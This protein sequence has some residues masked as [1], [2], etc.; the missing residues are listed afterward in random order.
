MASVLKVAF[1][2]SDFLGLCLERLLSRPDVAV[3]TVYAFDTDDHQRIKFVAGHAGVPLILEP[4][5]LER[6]AD[7]MRNVDVILTAGYGRKVPDFGVRFA[8]NLHPTLLP[9]GRGPWPIPW[10]LSDY[11][12]GGGVTL[13]AHTSRFDEGP[14]V[15]QRQIP[16][17]DRL[18]FEAYAMICNQLGV[19]IVSRFFDQPEAQ[20][21]A[22][23]PQEPDGI[24]S[25]RAFPDHRR[26][27]TGDLPGAVIIERIRRMGP[28]GAFWTSA[29]CE[30]GSLAVNLSPI[31]SGGPTKRFSNTTAS[32]ARYAAL[33]VL[34]CSVPQ[35]C[36]ACRVEWI[37]ELP[38]RVERDATSPIGIGRT[39]RPQ[40][41][42]RVHIGHAHKT[43]L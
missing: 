27:I 42:F 20:F 30:S 12:E 13:H 7:L 17:A 40:P 16:G 19:E 11:P 2:G 26:V 6:H 5:N 15:A 9:I 29:P 18:S 4:V 43:S 24:P 21:H 25:L 3:Q 8:V 41:A 23:R 39:A 33:T 22:A 35:S 14:I 10:I 36:T 37:V 38:W 32:T 28:M 34:S 1:L 31:P